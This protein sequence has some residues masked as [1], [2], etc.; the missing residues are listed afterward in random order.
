MLGAF[1]GPRILEELEDLSKGGAWV[2]WE[3][4]CQKGGLTVRKRLGEQMSLIENGS[5][6]LRIVQVL[7]CEFRAFC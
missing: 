6:V 4:S 3:D 7:H 5:S 1:L 2:N